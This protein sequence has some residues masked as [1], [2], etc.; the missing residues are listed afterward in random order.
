MNTKDLVLNIIPK[1]RTELEE[2]PWNLPLSK[3][4]NKKVKFISIRK[5]LSKHTVRFIKTKNFSFAIKQTNPISAYFE[6]E[7]YQKLLQTGVHTLIPAGYVIYKKNLFE[8]DSQLKTDSLAFMIT[9]VEDKTI[10]HSILFKLDFNE[11]NRQIIYEAIAVLIANLHSKNIFW[12]DASLANVLIKFIKTKDDKGEIKTGLKAFLSD[13]ETIEIEEKINDE[14]R[15]KDLKHLCNSMEK[16][17]K[18]FINE[19]II[20]EQLNLEEDINFIKEK[21]ENN[22]SLLKKIIEFESQTGLNVKQYFYTISD[23]YSLDSILKQIE[24]HKWYLSESSSKEVSLKESADDWIKNVYLPIIDEFE[25][26]KVF[27]FFPD[28]NSS[29]L[30]TDIM[31]HKYY[32]SLENGKDVGVFNA[33]KSYAE[34]YSNKEASGFQKLIEKLLGNIL[35]VVPQ[36]YTLL[37]QVSE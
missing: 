8:K 35:K 6:T 16:L 25:A 4:N 23:Q 34:K 5:G 1:Y 19:G 20:R 30:Y 29:K 22:Y 17:N 18:K 10:P 21:Y 12:G 11:G 14:K 37:T 33:I 26:N 27:D 3:W 24:E 36:N 15:E 28:T 2:L 13:A 9:I 7:T 31:A 32:L